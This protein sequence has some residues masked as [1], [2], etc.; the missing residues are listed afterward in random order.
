MPTSRWWIPK[1]IRSDLWKS[2]ETNYQ[3]MI[4]KS[5]IFIIL[6]AQ[7]TKDLRWWINC[8]QAIALKHII[9]GIC[10]GLFASW[11]FVRHWVKD[12]L[13]DISY[14]AYEI[15]R[16]ILV[17]LNAISISWQWY[18]KTLIYPDGNLVIFK[19]KQA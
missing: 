14:L 10:H 2:L 1:P 19:M 9:L 5:S 7:I 12:W 16:I 11:N 13:K 4:N 8:Y 3:Q 18:F 17:L 15:P 6:I